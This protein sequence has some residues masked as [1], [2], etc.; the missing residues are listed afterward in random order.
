MLFSVIPI[1]Q[2]SKKQI[3]NL[4]DL[5]TSLHSPQHPSFI[6]FF[7]PSQSKLHQCHFTLNHSPPR[8]ALHHMQKK[9]NHTTFSHV[10]FKFWC[11]IC[12]NN[13]WLPTFSHHNYIV[14]KDMNYETLNLSVHTKN[15][16]TTMSLRVTSGPQGSIIEQQSIVAFY[17]LITNFHQNVKVKWKK[18]KRNHFGQFCWKSKQKNITHQISIVGSNG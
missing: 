9:T 11:L 8:L 7:H 2:H 3:L 4:Q 5:T 12:I 17:F 18:W 10:L 6:F 1:K 14:D 13:N 16:S 15:P